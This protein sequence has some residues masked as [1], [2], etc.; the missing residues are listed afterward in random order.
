MDL[1]RGVLT[2]VVPGTLIGSAALTYPLARVLLWRYR[3]SVDRSMCSAS[4]SAAEEGAAIGAAP[5]APATMLRE[6]EAAGS[7]EG[8]YN[9]PWRTAA[10]YAV[11]GAAFSAI[12]TIARQLLIADGAPPLTRMLVVFWTHYWP[13]VLTVNLIITSSRRRFFVNASYFAVLAAIHVF[14]LIRNP[15]MRW[16]DL[17]VL[18]LVSNAVPTLVLL[19][20]LTRRIRA[21]GPLVLTFLVTAIMGGQ[22][23]FSVFMDRAPAAASALA[24]ALFDLGLNARHVFWGFQ[25]VPIAGFAV[26]GW[27]VLRWLARQYEQRRFSDEMLTIDAIWLLFAVVTSISFTFEGTGWVVTGLLAFAAFKAALLLGFALVPR[28]PNPRTLLL[29]RVFALG[30]RSEKLFDVLRA[31]WL[32]Q[33]PISLVAGPDLITSTIEPHELLRFVTGKLASEFVADRADLERRLGSLDARPDPDGRY[34]VDEFF[35]RVNTWQ[36]TMR[37]LAA[38]SDAVLMDLR[39][40]TSA[41][42]GCLYELGELLNVVDLERVVLVVDPTTQR[43]FLTDSL[44]KCWSNLAADSVNRRYT[45]PAIRIVTMP[46]TLTT[47]AIRRLLASLGNVAPPLRSDVLRAA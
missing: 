32:R 11:A 30:A 17:P 7:H 33:G 4:A 36:P 6:V 9:T 3:R 41:N 44:R 23:L 8:L 37:A 43:P 46:Q 24:G 19:A 12:F 40:F 10:V 47:D 26:I 1:A 42:A 45:A 13:A 18:W 2:A 29:L 39:G 22:V 16:Y 15:Q 34:R 20:Y 38:R 14:A 25:L 35:C 5:A 27:L 31:H 28:P 21:V